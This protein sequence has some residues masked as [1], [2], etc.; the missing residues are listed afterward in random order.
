MMVQTS[1]ART[2][3]TQIPESSPESFLKEVERDTRNLM[4]ALANAQFALGEMESKHADQTRRL[5]LDL[6]GVEDAFARVFRS[7]NAKRDGATH[8]MEVWLE[9]F[10]TVQSLLEAAL[11]A[12]GVVRME[13]LAQRFD[14]HAHTVAN[15]VADSTKA[16]GTILEVAAP[17]YVWRD[18]VL[19]K[20]QV[21]VVHNSEPGGKSQRVQK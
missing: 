14:P 15:R 1:D 12:Q 19:R 3:L 5:L 18:Q 4:S 9:S 6:V 10:R 8:D 20:P 2:I 21:I 13:N 17:G 7:I 11:S 16:E